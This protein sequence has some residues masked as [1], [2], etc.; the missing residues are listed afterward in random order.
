MFILFLDLEWIYKLLKP[1]DW[2]K[3]FFI[4]YRATVGA[5]QPISIPRA[6]RPV[7]RIVPRLPNWSW[8]PIPSKSRKQSN[9]EV[10]GFKSC[11]NRSGSTST[12]WTSAA[13]TS[14]TWRR[15]RRRK[16]RK[17][18]CPKLSG[19]EK[20]EWSS[21]TLKPSTSGIESKKI[22]FPRWL[23]NNFNYII[24]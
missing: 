4:V 5:R 20:T 21:E 2:I 7:P 6:A 3:T 22:F 16:I 17:S 1:S 9:K 13:S 14:S 12:I 18:R 24:V 15:R 10:T 23:K 8:L 19:K 11:S